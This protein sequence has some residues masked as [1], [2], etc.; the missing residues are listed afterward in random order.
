[1]NSISLVAGVLTG[2]DNLHVGGA[3][4][5]M[6]M[7]SQRRLAFAAAFAVAELGMTAVGYLAAVRLDGDL[8]AGLALAVAGALVLWAWLRGDELARLASHPAAL[9]VL[10]LALSFDNLAAGASLAAAGSSGWTGALAAGLTS[11]GM[12]GVGLFVGG[13]LGRRASRFAAPM[14][15]VLLLALATVGFVEALA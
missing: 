4:G 9:V 1:M 10:P 14:A 2:S 12:A 6:P 7:T 13:V 11:A 15:G 8:P 3:L 5:L